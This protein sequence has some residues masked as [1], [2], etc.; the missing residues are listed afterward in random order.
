MIVLLVIACGDSS[1]P[2]PG[3]DGGGPV[4]CGQLD[5]PCCTGIVNDAATQVCNN[6]TKCEDGTCVEIVPVWDVDAGRT[7]AALPCG[8][9]GYPC[10]LYA[11]Q[12]VFFCYEPYTCDGKVCR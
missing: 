1:W 6:D 2:E 4:S 10:C 11:P 12:N 5:E 7:D 9:L 3:L 8:L